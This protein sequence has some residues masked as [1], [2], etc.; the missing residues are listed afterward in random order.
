[1]KVPLHKFCMYFCFHRVAL[2]PDCKMPVSSLAKIFGPTI[3]GYSSMDPEP[4]TMLN[5]TKKQAA[6]SN[7][8]ALLTRCCSDF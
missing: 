1:M 6:V 2:C 4:L 5:E 3:V 8:Y 7:C